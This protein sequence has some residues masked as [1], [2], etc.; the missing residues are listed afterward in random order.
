[1]YSFLAEHLFFVEN[2]ST[3]I[4]TLRNRKCLNTGE[5]PFPFDVC[6]VE[7]HLQDTRPSKHFK[8]RHTGFKDRYL[9]S[10]E[11]KNMIML[12]T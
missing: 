9:W 4:A 5:N 1:M 3:K 12:G 8:G 6:D 7:R 10:L 11:E 2:P